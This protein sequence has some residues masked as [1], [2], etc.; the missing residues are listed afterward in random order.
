[1]PDSVY[2]RYFSEDIPYILSPWQQIASM[3]QIKT[4]ILNAVITLAQVLINEGNPFS[5][6]NIP[7]FMVE[8]YDYAKILRGTT[9][10]KCQRYQYIGSAL[11]VE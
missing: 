9:K 7:R 11:F 2:H 6:R 1:M 4:P 8:K 5:N 3:L 10:E